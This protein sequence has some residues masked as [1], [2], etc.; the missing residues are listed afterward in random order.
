MHFLN[1]ARQAGRVGHVAMVQ[2]KRLA[3]LMQVMEQMIDAGGIEQGAA[4]FDAVHFIPFVQKHFSEVG[5]VLPRDACDQRN[6][7]G[8]AHFRYFF[9]TSNHPSQPAHS[10][11]KRP[12]GP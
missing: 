10:A 8:F 7:S 11:A 1:D 12:P 9:A 3:G 4:A 5:S 6:L 2:K